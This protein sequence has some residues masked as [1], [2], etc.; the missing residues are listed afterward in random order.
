LLTQSI[1]DKGTQYLT[2]ITFNKFV[3]DLYG[4]QY[5]NS[6][7]DNN[8]LLLMYALDHELWL[9]TQQ[10]NAIFDQIAYAHR[11]PLTNTCSTDHSIWIKPC[12]NATQIVQDAVP[13]APVIIPPPVTFEFKFGSTAADTTGAPLTDANYIASVDAV[14]AALG[15]Y[16]STQI[17]DLDITVTT[18]YNATDKVLFLQVPPVE[19]PFTKW[20]EVGNPFQQN[21]PIDSSFGTGSGVWY[22]T[23]RAGNA[24]Y[25]TRSQTTIIGAVIFSR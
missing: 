21:Q 10:K 8:L 3:K 7:L 9:T 16:S 19:L 13:D 1:I 2:N 17:H 22:K 20:S 11:D 5:K 6:N 4:V 12:Y 18:F 24:L 23:T 15:E 14:L 25:L